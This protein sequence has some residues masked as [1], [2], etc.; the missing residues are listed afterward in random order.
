MKATDNE[1]ASFKR[2]CAE[3]ARLPLVIGVGQ[4]ILITVALRDLPYC[5]Y[6][7]MFR[8]AAALIVNP[9]LLEGIQS[10][11]KALTW[12]TY[13]QLLEIQEITFREAGILGIVPKCPGDDPTGQIWT[14]EIGPLIE[15]RF[16]E[17]EAPQRYP[18]GE[19]RP[20]PKIAE[21]VRVRLFG[22]ARGPL[23]KF[24]TELDLP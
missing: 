16:R 22:P 4:A 11:W 12:V 5:W 20:V 19:G 13:A 17:I 7:Q 9:L 18:W 10:L 21:K 14:Y 2:T 15:V 8:F 24:K 1:T 6:G 3:E 23:R